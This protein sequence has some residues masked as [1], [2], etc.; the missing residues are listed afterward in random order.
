[1]PART[2]T[3]RLPRLLDTLRQQHGPLSPPPAHNAFELVLWEKV[4]YLASDERR[5]AVFAQLRSRV[6]LTPDAI[7]AANRTTI[8][9]ILAQ[10]GMSAVERASN[11]IATAELIIG[12]FEGSLDDICAASLAD[13]KK[14][15][16]RIRGIADP[17][18]EKILLLTRTHPVLGLDS[19][20]LRVLTRLG[21]GTATKSYAATYRSATASAMAEL[22][23]DFEP[24]IDAHL[25]LRRHGQ[26]V[27][28]TTSPR[29][30]AC[31]LRNDCPTATSPPPV[32]TAR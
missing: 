25:E 23:T 16:K 32:A 10:G 20:G 19:N 6:G 22:G 14:Q 8:I 7:L 21:Y 29:C 5:A 3:P 27:C 28:K 2:T 24:L 4:A 11:V 18:A 12:E 31:V 26:T 30:G 1:M 17:G 15:L 9:E 13:A